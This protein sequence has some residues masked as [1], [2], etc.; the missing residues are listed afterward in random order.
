MDGLRQRKKQHTRQALSDAATRLFADNGFDAVTTAQIAAA[1][2]VAVGT[3][4]NYFKTK[5]DLFFDRAEDLTRAAAAAIRDRP[6]GLPA[7]AAFRRW[8][9]REISFLLDPRGADTVQRFFRT[10]AASPSLRAAERR[11]HQDI[12]YAVGQALRAGVPA[13]DPTPEVLAALLVAIH[14][15]VVETVRKLTLDGVPE[16]QRKHR[17]AQVA[18]AGF[19]GLAPEL[20]GGTT[21]STEVPAPHPADADFTQQ[22]QA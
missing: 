13:D 22:G 19:A 9:D 5:E 15:V 6:P 1:A 4:F 2:G 12:E 3:V 20:R 7:V 17:V 10:I 16:K 11:L 18:E 8:H 21:M 14:R